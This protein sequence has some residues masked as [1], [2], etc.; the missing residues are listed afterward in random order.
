MIS[1]V[2]DNQQSLISVYFIWGKDNTLLIFLI[3]LQ[4]VNSQRSTVNSQHST[5]GAENLNP[6]H[7]DVAVRFFF[8]TFAGIVELSLFRIITSYG[9]HCIQQNEHIE[10][11]RGKRYPFELKR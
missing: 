4:F 2:F 5:N 8:R 9:K 6:E 11:H 10:Q 7:K 3:L 1:V